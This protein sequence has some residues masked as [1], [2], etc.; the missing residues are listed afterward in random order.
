MEKQR[1]CMLVKRENLVE[2]LS[3]KGNAVKLSAVDVIDNYSK[4]F[5]RLAD[6]AEPAP[7]RTE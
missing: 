4:L 1:T 5:T 7:Q 6:T 2:E 3:K